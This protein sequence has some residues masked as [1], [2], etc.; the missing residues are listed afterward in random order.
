MVEAATA[1]GLEKKLVGDEA[2]EY[3]FRT[4]SDSESLYCEFQPEL[5]L[6]MELS[7]DRS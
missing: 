4:T 5:E 6:E 2:A 3:I 7:G 1:A